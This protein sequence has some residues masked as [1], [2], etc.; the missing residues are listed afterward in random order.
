[1]PDPRVCVRKRNG[2]WFLS[3][4]GVFPAKGFDNH[5]DAL[6]YGALV[7]W[8]HGQVHASRPAPAGL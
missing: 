2:K 3:R 8:N 5:L 6:T 7:N 4:D 1:M